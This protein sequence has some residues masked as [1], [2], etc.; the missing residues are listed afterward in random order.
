MALQGEFGV[1]K[2]NLIA[3]FLENI[4]Y[5]SEARPS[6]ATHNLKENHTFLIFS[7]W[8]REAAGW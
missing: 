4:R 6:G 7:L 2:V 3:R 1:F 5:F 8:L